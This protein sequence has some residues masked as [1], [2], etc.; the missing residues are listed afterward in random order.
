MQNPPAA[1]PPAAS[2][3]R[4]IPV[5]LG[6]V[7]ATFSLFGLI[8]FL[9]A[10]RTD[11]WEAWFYLAA[12]IAVTLA[13]GFF[14]LA[15]DP[16]L[17]RERVQAAGKGDVKFWDRIV[18]ALNLLLSLGLYAVI[19]LDA[20]RFGASVVPPALRIL[21]GCVILF[22]F[23]VTLSASRANTFLSSRVRIQ[24]ERGHR[25]VTAGPYR[26]IRHPM[27]AAMCLFNI[28]LPLLLG[29]WWGL[30]VGG[31]MIA[32]IAVRTALEDR[33]LQRELPGYAEYAR[34]V[35]RRLIPGVW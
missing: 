4:L 19:G 20:G 10:G 7:L 3:A 16:A 18:S 12:H 9:A 29:S 25:A 14:L 8:L 31:L 17:V 6:Q 28:G 23:A 13:A 2:K 5:Y 1:A 34:R 30:L 24:A 21:G 33:T 35:R 11:W 22:S 32:L 26:L 15:R 27:Y